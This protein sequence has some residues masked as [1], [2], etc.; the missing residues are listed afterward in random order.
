MKQSGSPL[1]WS[2]RFSMRCLIHPVLALVRSGWTTT[3]RFR[4]QTSSN[5]CSPVSYGYLW[6][7]VFLLQSTHEKQKKIENQE[8]NGAQGPPT[9][10]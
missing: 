8:G 1:L 10:V 9:N 3:T 6:I 7:A 2:P 5:G 4:R